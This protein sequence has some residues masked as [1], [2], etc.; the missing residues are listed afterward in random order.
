MSFRRQVAPGR[1][2]A[3]P[4]WF[5]VDGLDHLGEVSEKRRDQG[6]VIVA[7]IE[8]SLLAYCGACAGCGGGLAAAS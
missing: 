6:I 4:S 1:G 7:R 3:E 8:D 2:G 5:D